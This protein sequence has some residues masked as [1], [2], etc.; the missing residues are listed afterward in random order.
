MDEGTGLRKDR[1]CSEPRLLGK[2]REG[3]QESEG[4]RSAID[5][6]GV[7]GPHKVPQAS[8]GVG[9][10]RLK[11]VTSPLACSNLLCTN[12]QSTAINKGN[13]SL[14]APTF[15][16]S[17]TPHTTSNHTHGGKR[18][19]TTLSSKSTPC[20]DGGPASKNSSSH[21]ASKSA[22]NVIPATSSGASSGTPISEH[23]EMRRKETYTVV[24][25]RLEKVKGMAGPTSHS[26]KLQRRTNRNRAESA[27]S[28]IRTQP[29]T[30]DLG[31][32]GRTK[33]DL[34]PKRHESLV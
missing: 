5:I 15:N 8:A 31:S 7:T 11:P 2:R 22:T 34:P 10:G 27:G 18:E 19:R 12:N 9:G 29:H 21:A 25:P 1:C 17:A 4:S 6:G 20:L 3:E 32:R 26:E 24:A 33:S 28:G 13:S 14:G 16:G 30:P 23:R